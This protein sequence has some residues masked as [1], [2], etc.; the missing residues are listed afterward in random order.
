MQE[1]KITM[2]LEVT[3]TTENDKLNKEEIEGVAYWLV[4][5]AIESLEL[6]PVDN[7]MVTAFN[8]SVDEDKTE[9]NI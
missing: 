1:H 5:P 7:N 6:S 8:L 4:Q 2:T 3:I 9:I